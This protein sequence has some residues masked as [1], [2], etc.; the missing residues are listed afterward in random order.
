MRLRSAS[1]AAMTRDTSEWTSS[2]LSASSSRFSSAMR[3]K[4]MKSLDTRS[5]S[6]SRPFW[7]AM[8]RL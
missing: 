5:K 4:S 8:K 7:S 2:G 3:S 1:W 6:A